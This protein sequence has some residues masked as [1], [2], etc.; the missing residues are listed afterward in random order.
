M[1]AEGYKKLI[2]EDRLDLDYDKFEFSQE[3]F[4]KETENWDITN[5]QKL[6]QQ[7]IENGWNKKKIQREIVMHNARLGQ[8]AKAQEDGT[9]YLEKEEF[10][11]QFGKMPAGAF[12]AEIKDGQLVKFKKDDFSDLTPPKYSEEDMKVL[13]E[14]LNAL[15]VDYPQVFGEKEKEE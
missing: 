9:Q 12:V 13:E 15:Y 4:E 5:T 14:E 11:K 2:A 10:E 8:M 3:K 7:A 1:G 6:M